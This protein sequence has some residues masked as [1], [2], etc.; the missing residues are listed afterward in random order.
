MD[1]I[2]DA[3]CD[4]TSGTPEAPNCLYRARTNAGSHLPSVNGVQ[5]GDFGLAR[6]FTKRME[7][8]HGEGKLT[9]RVI[10]LWYRYAAGIPPSPTIV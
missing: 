10:T 3:P 8:G 9:N 2:C 1:L 7:Q 6:T 5:I 4:Q